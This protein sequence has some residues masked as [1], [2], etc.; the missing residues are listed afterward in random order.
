MRAL[1]FAEYLE[2]HARLV[3]GSGA[4]GEVAVAKL[5]LARI[6]KGDLTDGFCARDVRRK[7]WSG[8]TDN[9]QIRAGLELLADFDCVAPHTIET[10]GRPRTAYVV[11]PRSLR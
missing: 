8:L 6:R 2:S 4:A 10:P 7:E 9:D 5:I 1:A 11:I 3:Y